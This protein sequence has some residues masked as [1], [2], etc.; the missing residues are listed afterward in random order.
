MKMFHG[1]SFIIACSMAVILINMGLLLPARTGVSVANA[2]FPLPAFVSASVPAKSGQDGTR[3]AIDLEPASGPD[4]DLKLYASLN[5]DLDAVREGRGDVPR[6]TLASL[7][8]D[9]WRERE[10]SKRKALFLKSVLPLVLQVNE[11]I[12]QDRKRLK[13][14]A[15]AQK[16][17][18]LQ[19]LDR[20]WLA[21]MAERYGTKR[22]DINA[23]LNRHDVVPPSLALAQAATE[24]AWGS[25]RFVREGNA[26]F[27]QWTFSPQH[28]GIV[29]AGRDEGKTHRI[30]AFA[31]LYDSLD[32]YVTN[33]N[34][35]RAY[36]E[37]REMRSAMRRQGQPLDG[38][39]LAGT[40]H[41]Y[42][43][44]GADYVNELRAIIFSNDLRLVD[45][46]RL[47]PNATVEPLI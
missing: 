6:I 23:V 40:L 28:P 33:L 17:G 29:P 11:Q 24:S 39:R 18:P 31:S 8:S 42:S 26:M 21:V 7:P 44:R 46:A 15:T 30:R 19:A 35:H 25:S 9:L 34:K 10:T 37:F 3:L 47:S 45:G 14:L 32:S 12:T 41:R 13:N 27:G 36:K 38:L 22:G 20:L 16:Q 5:Y 4:A 2:S 43:E 1:V